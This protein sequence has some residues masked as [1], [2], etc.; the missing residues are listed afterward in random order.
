MLLTIDNQNISDSLVDLV[1]E[2]LDVGE[3]DL[4]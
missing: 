4:W 1:E 3:L 2:H